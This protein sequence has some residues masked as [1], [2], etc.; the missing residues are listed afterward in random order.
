[1]L[2]ECGDQCQMCGDE[3]PPEGAAN[4]HVHHL[5][6]DVDDD[7]EHDPSNLSVACRL[8]HSWIHH[9]PAPSDAPVPLLRADLDVLLPHDFLLLQVLDE[10]G[11]ASF[12]EIFT[13]VKVLLSE[14]AVRERLWVLMGLDRLVEERDEQLVDQDAVTRA[15]GFPAQ[16]KTS[17]RGHVPSD[18]ALLLQRAEDELVRRALARGS[19]R[20]PVSDAFGI[21]RRATF[22]KEYRAYAYAFPLDSFSRGGRP[23]ADQGDRGEDEASGVN[24]DES[25][26][27]RQREPSQ[28]SVPEEL[29]PVET[30]GDPEDAESTAASDSTLDE[31]L[32]ER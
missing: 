31:L 5:R 29:R 21:T 30:W 11:P 22:Y 14:S 27:E 6:R 26:V 24:G 17:A 2:Y 19:D 23:A 8:C 12:S 15:W 1:M 25:V 28:S 18:P 10:I 13:R 4:L 7:E 3:G 20:A 16:I 9:R 32:T